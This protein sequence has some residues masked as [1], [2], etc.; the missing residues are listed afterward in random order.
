MDRIEI[1][2]KK[3]QEK[4]LDALVVHNFE[5]SNRTNSWYISG[6]SGSFAILVITMKGK[7]IITDSR[8]Y[9]QVSLQS[10]FELIPYKTGNQLKDMVNELLKKCDAKKVGYEADKITHSVYEKLFAPLKV[11]EI[12]E[13]SSLITDMRAIKTP[14][15]IEKI[16]IAVDVAQK[17]LLETLNYIK[18]GV[19]EMEVCARLEY[20]M[21]KR[22]G[23]PSFETIIGSGEKSAVVHGAAGEKEIREGEFVLIDYGA[24][25]NGYCSDITRTFCV[26][27]PSD[28]MI[29]VYNVVKE[30]QEKARKAAKAGLPGRD[31]HKI[32]QDIIVDAGY[33]E[34]FGHGLGHSLGMDVHDAGVSAS[35]STETL[36]PVGGVLTIEPGIYLPGKFGVRIEDD[37]YLQENNSEVLTSLDRDLKIL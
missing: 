10:D 17:S 27:K 15:E 36:L 14:D 18:P 16:K 12:V 32:A 2:R 9:T 5:N 24:K 11:E 8:Y 37:V 30:A 28:E 22:G 29:K 33:G 31:L 13:C 35:P 34:Y 4:Q 3:L 6:F 23:S 1:L 7:Y 21:K 25:V 19:K 26:G 20:E